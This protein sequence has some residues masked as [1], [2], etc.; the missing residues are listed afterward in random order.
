MNAGMMISETEVKKVSL[1][2]TV[3]DHYDIS[4]VFK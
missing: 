4:T 3:V 2:Q 1:L